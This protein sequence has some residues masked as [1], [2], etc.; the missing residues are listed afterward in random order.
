MYPVH[1][2]FV[3]AHNFCSSPDRFC[4]PTS[5]LARQ[6]LDT[7]FTLEP[8]SLRTKTLSLRT[9]AMVSCVMGNYSNLLILTHSSFFQMLSTITNEE[10]EAS[11]NQFLDSVVKEP[12]PARVNEEAGMYEMPYMPPNSTTLRG[13]KHLLL[14]RRYLLEKSL[15]VSAAS[16]FSMTE[17]VERN[18]GSDRA[19]L[20]VLFREIPLQN[21]K[22]FHIL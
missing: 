4:Q 13:L 22:Y 14:Q 8:A 17:P 6:T 21:F 16:T 11:N 12:T 15:D 10:L 18:L 5:S 20:V 3:F 7:A 1:V 2:V 9:Y 19:E